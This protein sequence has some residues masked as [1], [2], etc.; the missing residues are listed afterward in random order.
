MDHHGNKYY[1]N[2]S[3]QVGRH[4]WVVFADQWDYSASSVPAEWHAWLHCIHDGAPSR[5]AYQHPSYELASWDGR[6]G[7]AAHSGATALTPERDL[8]F[9]KGHMKRGRRTWQRYEQWT[10]PAVA[11]AEKPGSG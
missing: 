4:R 2:R 11:A 7:S 3:Y 10:P 1:E 6:Y 8:H 5:H 9:P